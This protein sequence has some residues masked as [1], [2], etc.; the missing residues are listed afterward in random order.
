MS[1]KTE[2]PRREP[3]RRETALDIVRPGLCTRLDWDGVA[4]F[5]SVRIYEVDE[6]GGD[7]QAH[8]DARRVERVIGN[9]C[10]PMS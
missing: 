1:L 4:G 8:H 7:T 6:S 5:C 3:R 9:V 10:E 2:P